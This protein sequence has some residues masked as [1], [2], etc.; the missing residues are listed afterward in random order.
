MLLSKDELGTLGH[1]SDITPDAPQWTWGK[2]FTFT[3]ETKLVKV[4]CLS[5]N[6]WGDSRGSTCLEEQ[7]VWI[8]EGGNSI[9]KGAIRYMPEEAQVG[10]TYH[11]PSE[12]EFQG[13][14]LDML[15]KEH[16]CNSE[17]ELKEKVVS[18]RAERALK[19][20]QERAASRAKEEARKAYVS[21]LHAKVEEMNK[22][23]PIPYTIKY[24]GNKLWVS[25]EGS[26]Q[27]PV[28]EYAYEAYQI[29]NATKVLEQWFNGLPK[30]LITGKPAPV[31]RKK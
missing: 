12:E 3:G 18:I 27:N 20:E 26:L 2:T 24:D 11:V 15:C 6:R 28:K 16:G 5:F 9:H 31:K 30:P 25:T 19:E 22:Q 17:Q 4:P 23:V 21:S 1:W 8:D 14:I 10:D 13:V 29:E 7:G